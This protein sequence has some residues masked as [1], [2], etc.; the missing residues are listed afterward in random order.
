MDFLFDEFIEVERNNVKIRISASEIGVIIPE[1]IDHCTVI[2]R[3]GV[4]I[5]GVSMP[6]HV[7]YSK[8]KHVRER[9]LKYYMDF[10]KVTVYE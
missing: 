4:P 9:Q 8:V 5:E 6:A 1:N 3:G 2:L 10:A 7:L